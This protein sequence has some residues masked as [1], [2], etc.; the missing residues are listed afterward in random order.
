CMADRGWNE[1]WILEVDFGKISGDNPFGILLYI[2]R[3]VAFLEHHSHGDVHDLR[4]GAHGRKHMSNRHKTG[5]HAILMWVE[6]ILHQLHKF[7][8][9][10]HV[11]CVC[12]NRP[13]RAAAVPERLNTE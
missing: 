3:A 8:T 1:I 12:D 11:V 6:C 4:D 5:P 13:N 9:G 10:R 2:S 7:L